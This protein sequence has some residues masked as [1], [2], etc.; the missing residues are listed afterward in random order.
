MAAQPNSH[1]RHSIG[2]HPDLPTITEDLLESESEED[3]ITDNNILIDDNQSDSGSKVSY[4]NSYA[5]T[6][7]G[8]GFDEENSLISGICNG[9]VVNNNNERQ[10]LTPPQNN[11]GGGSHGDKRLESH[12]HDDDVEKKE[13]EHREACRKLGIPWSRT[14][15]DSDLGSDNNDGG[16]VSAAAKKKVKWPWP[17]MGGKVSPTSPPTLDTLD[18]HMRNYALSNTSGAKK[19]RKI[20]TRWNVKNGSA[21]IATIVLIA[22]CLIG[23]MVT[24]LTSNSDE[25]SIEAEVVVMKGHPRPKV[26]A[27]TQNVHGTVSAETSIHK[28]KAAKED[29]VAAKRLDHDDEE[30][31]CITDVCNVE[32]SHTCLLNYKVNTPTT[33]TD[34]NTITFELVCEGEAWIGIGFSNDGQMVG[35]EAVLGVPGGVPQKYVLG[36]KDNSSVMPV[37]VEKQTL[38]DASIQYWTKRGL[39]VMTFTKIM[40]EEGEVEIRSGEN[41][42]LYAQGMGVDLGYHATGESFTL[43]LPDIVETEEQ[44]VEVA[45]A[46]IEEPIVEDTAPPEEI[47]SEEATTDDGLDSSCIDQQ[48]KFKNRNNKNR[49][50]DWMSKSGDTL[51]S[52]LQD[53]ECGIQSLGTQPSELGLKCRYTCRAYNGCLLKDAQDVASEV[54]MVQPPPIDEAIDVDD[55]GGVAAPCTIDVCNLE[56]SHTCLLK[57]KVN[58][59]TLVTPV[60]TITLE[61]VCEGEAWIGI[62]FSNDG[63]MIG[64]EAVLG[65]PG[66]V[67]QKYVLGGKDNSSVMPMAAH[68]QTLTD[69]SVEYES[70]LT[71]LKFTKTMKEEGEVEIRSGENTFLYAQGMGVDLGYHA[72]GESFTLSLPGVEEEAPA[73]DTSIEIPLAGDTFIDASKGLL[74]YCSWLDIRHWSQ[75]QIRR[76]ANCNNELTQASCPTSCSAYIFIDEAPGKSQ[77]T[78]TIIDN[79]QDIELMRAPHVPLPRDDCFDTD[80]YFLDSNSTVRQCD[81]L[82]TNLDPLDETRKIYNCG[83]LKEPTDLGRMCKLSCGMCDW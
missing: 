60:N 72:T 26:S 69:A 56:L 21:L 51:H 42:F 48:G 32:L 10:H 53:R 52:N 13:L 8:V 6:L 49:S 27:A 77:D 78:K 9:S 43:T 76:D 82:N 80:G 71:I 70:G 46:T 62:G 79:S 68:K 74:R 39:T 44:A 59:P 45:T 81:W 63:Q 41:T 38:M 40:K 5:F 1:H 57:Y 17:D 24:A 15:S 67:P 73:A 61:L 3:S 29:D 19:R 36:G 7:D 12:R 16:G 65:V 20:N 47:G 25:D 33:A 18:E 50:C 28:T 37:A 11:R 22:L 54:D 66:S 4:A 83:Y 30:E 75:R 64:S 34:V 14:H 55:A 23:I 58:H 35:S 31:D 2:P